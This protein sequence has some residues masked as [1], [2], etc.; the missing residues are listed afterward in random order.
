MLVLYVVIA[1]RYIEGTK[2]VD[3]AL[4]V[5]LTNCT[6]KCLVK[7]RIGNEL[8]QANCREEM[9]DYDMGINIQFGKLIFGGD[10]KSNMKD[11]DRHC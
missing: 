9:R 10:G 1:R 4:N 7:C 6:G 8:S 5:Q 3:R 2:A 11:R